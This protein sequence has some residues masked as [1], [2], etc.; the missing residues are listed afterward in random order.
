MTPSDIES[1]DQGRV[2]EIPGTD[3]RL[4]IP[5]DELAFAYSRSGGPGGQHVN[6]TETRV[7]LQFDVANSPSLN[8]QQRA[9][10]LARLRNRIDKEGIL[11]VIAATTRSQASN[12]AAAIERFQVLVQR[13]LHE[14][15]PRIATRPSAGAVR[16]RMEAKRQRSVVKRRRGRVERD[17]E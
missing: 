12:R 9:R 13:A 1:D 2:I 8:E 17:E 7:E 5:V 10:L 6:K 4:V 15:R 3:P 14:E 11:H 16:R